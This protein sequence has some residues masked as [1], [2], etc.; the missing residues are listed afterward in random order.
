[1]AISEF[2]LSVG[3]GISGRQL[4]LFELIASKVSEKRR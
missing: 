1:M 2:V 4:L 3:A